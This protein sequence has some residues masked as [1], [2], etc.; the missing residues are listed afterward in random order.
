MSRTILFVAAVAACL[1]VVGVFALQSHSAQA[2]TPTP[3]TG[4]TLHIDALK[5]FGSAHP[6]EVAHHWCKAVS[7][8][9]TQCLLFDSDG[10]G[11]RIVGV[12]SVVPTAVWKTF[13]AS[14]RALWHYHRWEIPR[15][16]ATLPDLAPAQAKKVAASLMETYGKIFLFWDPMSSQ[17]PTGQ[18]RAIILH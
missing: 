6:N 9:L 1:I 17:Y 5:H 13:P 11:G 18:P 4:Y 14:E 7:P 8:T 10:P 2:M 16:H 3:V 12:E 15:V